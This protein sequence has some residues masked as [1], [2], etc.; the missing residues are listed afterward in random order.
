MH[1]AQGKMISIKLVLCNLTIVAINGCNDSTQW[2]D[3]CLIE[4][5][6]SNETLY[7]PCP[8]WRRKEDACKS[9]CYSCLL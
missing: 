9:R 4:L 6:G 2:S 5:K 3:S 1:T 8:R 7:K